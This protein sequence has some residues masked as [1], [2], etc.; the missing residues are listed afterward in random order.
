[1]A[2]GSQSNMCCVERAT[3]STT[4]TTGKCILAA[5]PATLPTKVPVTIGVIRRDRGVDR[6]YADGTPL[7]STSISFQK[8][9]T[10]PHRAPCSI[11]PIFNGI[12]LHAMTLIHLFANSSDLSTMLC[13]TGWS[14]ND[15][16]QNCYYIQN[17]VTSNHALY[18]NQSDAEAICAQM[19]AHLASIHTQR[20]N[21]WIRNFIATYGGVDCGQGGQA[22]IGASCKDGKKTWSDGTTFDYDLTNGNC[23]DAY[24]ENLFPALSGTQTTALIG[25]VNKNN[26]SRINADGTLLNYWRFAS[27]DEYSKPDGCTVLNFTDFNWY[28]A[29]CATSNPFI[30]AFSD[31]GGA[32]CSSGWTFNE[33]TGKCY[34]LQNVLQNDSIPMYTRSTAET[35]C[36]SMG[37]H[38]ASIH[39]DAEDIFI[40]NLAATSRKDEMC[41]DW[42]VVI[43]ATCS[44]T[45]GKTWTDGSP[46]NYDLTDGECVES[47]TIVNDEH[48]RGSLQN[49]WDSHDNFK[50]AHFVCKRDPQ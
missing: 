31:Q 1:M 44:E 27:A 7:Y 17:I 12:P 29:S 47:Y 49:I 13:P 28:S 18:V 50:Y 6:I 48:C 39:S 25:V 24:T 14:W 22:L 35:M 4:N 32:Q 36:Q 34:Y 2:I 45:E 38:L 10:Q 42:G 15:F 9:S 16:T 37:A 21:I 46:F 30:C 20:E 33:L 19:G 40:R 41:V 43:G 8:A 26:Q 23:T 5:V 3:H 11:Q